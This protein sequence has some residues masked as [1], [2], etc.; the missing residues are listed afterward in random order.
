MNFNGLIK[1]LLVTKVDTFLEISK[2]LEILYS[3][4]HHVFILAVEAECVCC[5]EYHDQ[6]VTE[7]FHRLKCLVCSLCEL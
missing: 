2:V 6:K 3:W 5:K 1:F 4:M 7:K